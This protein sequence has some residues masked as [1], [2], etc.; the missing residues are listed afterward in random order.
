[1]AKENP[2][3]TFVHVCDKKYTV[4][5]NDKGGLKALRYGEPWRDCCGD[6]LIFHLASEL[7][8]AR[9]KLNSKV[10]KFDLF[11]AL[12][13]L[14]ETFGVDA[15]LKVHFGDCGGRLEASITHNRDK[16]YLTFE[17]SIFEMKSNA[18]GL[19][20]NQNFSRLMSSL[21]AVVEGDINHNG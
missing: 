5:I 11:D 13:Q 3:Q 8:E 10:V 21:K 2:E 1:M 4:V 20:M 18:L 14:R 17:I 12:S 15:E 19:I 9:K 6:N 16:Y 7:E